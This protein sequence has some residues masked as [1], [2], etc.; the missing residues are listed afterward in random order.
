MICT[1]SQLKYF[2]RKKEELIE[3]LISVEDIFSKL[4]HLT[5]RFDDFLRRY[6]LLLISVTSV[7][8]GFVLNVTILII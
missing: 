7:N 4:S 8:L 3:K 2:Q 6:Y 5:N 1:R